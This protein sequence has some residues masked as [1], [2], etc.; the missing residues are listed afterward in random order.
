MP[1]IVVILPDAQEVRVRLHARQQMKDG[2]RYQV[3][4]LIWQDGV[5][6]IAEAVEQ[7]MWVAPGHARPIPG[8]SYEHVPTQRLSATGT[9]VQAVHT[10][11]TCSYSG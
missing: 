10:L 6:G 7:R 5:E 8:V 2:W 11:L 4:I 1:P 3:G 9:I